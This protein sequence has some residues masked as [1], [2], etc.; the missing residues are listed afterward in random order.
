MPT[1]HDRLASNKAA[2]VANARCSDNL[3][4][5]AVAMA[6]TSM[7][8]DRPKPSVR[9]SEAPPNRQASVATTS[10]TSRKRLSELRSC[11]PLASTCCQCPRRTWLRE[12]SMINA[13]N[14]ASP[15]S[16][17]PAWR[18]SPCRT[19]NASTATGITTSG[20]PRMET[21]RATSSVMW[22]AYCARW[23]AWVATVRKLNAQRSSSTGLS[24][25]R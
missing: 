19:I 11:L 10:K 8:A 15:A 16:A 14:S 17:Q 2:K 25:G 21:V 12:N 5:R 3:H 24:Q 20:W 4:Q 22:P 9:G 7:A 1:H 6:T 23:I 18:P 13:P